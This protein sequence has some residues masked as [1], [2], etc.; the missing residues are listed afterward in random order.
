MNN[1]KFLGFTFTNLEINKLVEYICLRFKLKKK[2]IIST[3]NAAKIIQSNNDKFLKNFIKG[4]SITTIDGMSIAF[5]GKLLI[6][7]KLYRV[8]GYDLMEKLF[9]LSLKKN[10]SLYFL[11]ARKEVVKKAVKRVKKEYPKIPICGF[12]DG[13][14]WNKEKLLI[15]K[16]NRL[17]PKILLIGMTSPTQERFVQKYKNFLDVKLIILLGGSFDVLS[18]N[19]KRAPIIF[20]KLGLEWF[21]RLIQEPRRLFWR[22]LT[23]NSQFIYIV[24][25]QYFNKKIKFN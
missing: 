20:Q 8:S 5:A 12:N 25:K 24:L 15:K 4:S 16:I 22:Y 18:G 13:Y 11:G 6:K 23:T 19:L 3:V 14:F 10:F 21:F 17:K 7:K 9:Q 1:I 2:I